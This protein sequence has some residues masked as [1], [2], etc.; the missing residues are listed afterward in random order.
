MNRKKRIA[1]LLALYLIQRRR[2]RNI[3]K[4]RTIYVRRSHQKDIQ[5]RFKIFWR[6]Y[7]SNREED[8]REFCRF[9]KG[10]FDLLYVKVKPYLSTHAHTH[11][12]PISSKERLAVFLRLF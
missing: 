2:R 3:P 1:I 9:T 12:W 10:H 11:R 6:Y 7:N 5:H 8:L 4:N